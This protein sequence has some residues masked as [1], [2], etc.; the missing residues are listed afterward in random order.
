MTQPEIKVLP[1]PAA[2][3]A[4]AAERVVRSA[5]EAIALA[6]RFSFV[7]AGG[8][9]PKALYELL[10][11]DAYRDRV[12]WAKVEIYFGDERTVPP[13]HKDSNYRM[14]RETLLA[15]V[16]IPGDNVYR[17]RGEIDPQEAAKEYGLM[18]KE[19]FPA[20]TSGQVQNGETWGGADLLLLGMGEDGHTASLFPG[21][22]ALRETKHRVVANPVPQLNTTRLTMTAPF[23]NRSR[24]VILT[25]TGASKAQRLAEVLEGPR[26]PE[27]LPVQLIAPASGKMTW[28]IDATAAEM[29]DSDH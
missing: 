5:D 13:D 28:L 1:D 25:V 9:T 20:I 23:L 22:P 21:T 15:K 19:K 27:R 18:L 26:D 29:T 16:P 7:L 24:T 11:S 3:A 8:S 14:A 6:G 17:M 12:D 2:V 10:A 4:E